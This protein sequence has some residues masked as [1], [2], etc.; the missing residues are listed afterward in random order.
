MIESVIYMKVERPMKKTIVQAAG[1]ITL[2]AIF[3]KLLG[4]GRE[5]LMAS[6]FGTSPTSDAYFVA[7]IIPVLLFTAVGMAITTGMVPL[8]AEAKKK[9]K[10]EASEIM[11]VLTTLFL[12]L[13]F[14]V[15]LICLVL[16]PYITKIMAPGFSDQQLELTNML[17]IIMLPSFCFYVLSAVTTGILEYEKV[18]APP[19]LGAIPQNI[20]II[21]AIVLLTNVYGI[22]GIAAATLLGAV[23]QF[24]V[25][26]P[27]IRKYNVLKLNFN[28]KAHKKLF[29]DTFLAL[30]PMIIASIAYQLNAVVDRMIASSLQTGSVSALN[31]ANK[32]MFLPLSIVLLSFITVLFPSIVDAAAEKS[33]HFVHLIFQGINV[34]SLIGIP[35]MAVMLIESETL[36]NIA[37]KRGAFDDEASLLTTT[38]FFFY[39]FGMIFIALK[40]FLNR[41]FI[42]IHQPKITMIASVASIVANIILSLILSRYFG[43]GGIALATSIA[44][45]LQTLFLFMYLPRKTEVDPAEMKSFLYST[46]KLMLL[47]ALVFALLYFIHPLYE[48]LHPILSFFVSAL[49]AFIF[50]AIG[51]LLF[52][53]KEMQWMAAYFKSKLRRNKH[54]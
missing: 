25:Q 16:T 29:K 33:K 49:C 17:T 4:F 51:S 22:Y 43:V 47:F 1:M 26:Y 45:M 34:I 8:Y 10:T 35:I 37:Y 44:M 27:F 50:T 19:A 12:V 53:L 9:S 30:S 32:L 6:Y 41:S 18:F 39:S 52:R 28:F 38:A 31:Y 23:S 42:A 46:L 14:I 7:S 48:T 36:V 24:L 40:E 54:G 11:S 20:L 13:S 3:S 15:T 21:L 2:I 5:L